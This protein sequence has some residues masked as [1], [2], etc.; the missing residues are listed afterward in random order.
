[1]RVTCGGGGSPHGGGWVLDTS[2][3]RG[4]PIEQI[5]NAAWSPGGNHSWFP[6]GVDSV[7]L[8]LVCVRNRGVLL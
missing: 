7:G 4:Q 2:R 1:M 6:W 5:V 3:V 8:K